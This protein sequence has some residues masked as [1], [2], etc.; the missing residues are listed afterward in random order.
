MTLARIPAE[1]AVKIFIMN[2]WKLRL[3]DMPK[4]IPRYLLLSVPEMLS[5]ERILI[6]GI[7]ASFI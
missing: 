4:A 2:M 7:S 1:S 6:P 3:P 5:L